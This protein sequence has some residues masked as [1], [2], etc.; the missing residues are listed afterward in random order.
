MEGKTS[1]IVSLSEDPSEE[2]MH[3]NKVGV[4][5]PRIYVKCHPFYVSIKIRDKIAHC[6]LIDGGLGPNVMSKIIM[7]ELG[8]SCTNENSKSMWSNNSQQQ[9][10]IGEIKDVALVLCAH[11]K[12]RTT[13]NIQVIYMPINNYYI[14]L[15]RY[16]QELTSG[17][18]SLDGSHMSL[19]KNG[20]NIVVLKEGQISPYIESLLQPHVNYIE[21]NLGVYSN[22]LED[23]EFKY[24]LIEKHT[25][26]LV[27]SI[28]KFHQYILGKHM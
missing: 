17:Y 23:D 16:W 10:T 2:R 1:T 3:I 26:F 20:K 12:I 9:V 18:I 6:Y 25:Y 22:F 11:L 15:G 8:L 19:P 21:E 13:C 4:Y 14:I 24:I 27:K 5:N 7:E 28:K